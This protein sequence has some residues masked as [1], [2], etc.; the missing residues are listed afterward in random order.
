MQKIRKLLFSLLKA[1][2][3]G[4]FGG[5]FVL[6]VLLVED[7]LMRVPCNPKFS[8]DTG[9]RGVA[10]GGV[11]IGAMLSIILWDLV[12]GKIIKSNFA[13]WFLILITTS[14]TAI[15]LETVYL[16]SISDMTIEQIISVS[17]GGG[18]MS[19]LLGIDL[20][21][22]LFIILTPFTLLFANY[23]LII[24]KIKNLNTLK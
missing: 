2:A 13:K 22:K 23:H 15:L 1:I 6:T 5:V 7:F 18:R 19:G 16:I 3:Y 8:C 12:F 4:F 17:V 9:G 20:M 21:I 14:I 24:E 11:L 10:P